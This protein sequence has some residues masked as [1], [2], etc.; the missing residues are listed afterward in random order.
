MLIWILFVFA[1]VIAAYI[2][3]SMLLRPHALTDEPGS[4]VE[5][6]AENRRKRL[7]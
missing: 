2:A 7:G 4:V 5:F 1:A 6:P 3:I